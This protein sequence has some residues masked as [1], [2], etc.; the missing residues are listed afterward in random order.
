MFLMY[1]LQLIINNQI[2]DKYLP[3]VQRLVLAQCKVQQKTITWQR[4]SR[5]KGFFLSFKNTN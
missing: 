4:C 3:A 1:H 5:K 2:Y